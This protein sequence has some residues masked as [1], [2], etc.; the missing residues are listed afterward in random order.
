MPTSYEVIIG[1]EVHVQLKTKTKAFCPAPYYYGAEPNTLTDA[2]VLALPGVLPT[3]NKAA[4]D[5]MI[6]M[7]LMFNCAI[8]KE[9]KWDRK[10]YWYPDSPKN[11]QISQY[12]QPLCI[13]GKVEIELPGATRGICGEHK[14][15]DLTRIHLEEDPAKLNHSGN[16]SLIDDNRNGASLAEIVSEPV[17]RS[18]DEAAAFINALRLALSQQGISDC[19]MEKGQMR[20]DANVSVR[21][22]GQT[23][24][25]TRT[26]SKNLNSVSAVK[27]CIEWESRRQIGL[28]DA[29]RGAEIVQETRRWNAEEGFGYTMRSKEDSQD[30]RYFPDPDLMPVRVDEVWKDAIRATIAELPYDRQRRYMEGMGLPYSTASAL[31]PDLALCNY[32]ENAVAACNKP[33]EIANY[34]VND[35]LRELSKKTQGILDE[36]QKKADRYAAEK[37]LDAQMEEYQRLDNSTDV[38]NK[39]SEHVE[40]F[41][42]G[43]TLYTQLTPAHLA[44][45]VK[46]T[47]DGVITKQIA[48]EVFVE[49]FRS[50]EA[51]LSIVDKKGLR[52]QNDSGELEKLARAAIENDPSAVAKFK[53]GNDKAINALKGPIMKA[54][55]GKADPKTIDEVL[56]KLLAQA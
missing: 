20:C 11:Y 4:I 41:N 32:F 5:L 6:K 55:K 51:P 34:V 29:G 21:P 12:D 37:R 42:N 43:D 38:K 16:F 28:Y 18:G 46:L 35:L 33:A 53:A 31:I 50:G 23:K 49:S 39:I 48:H 26:E 54:T 19:D 40:S 7:G 47:D 10:N 1:L 22:V 17:F 45:L 56:R 15:M 52:T 27:A 13:G 44:E 9:C 3:I 14:W 24:L 30:Y 36:Y 8:A 2:V 25:N